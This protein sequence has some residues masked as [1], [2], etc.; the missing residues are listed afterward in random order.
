LA[1]R[2]DLKGLITSAT[3]DPESFAQHFADAQ[4]T[5]SPII[6]VSGRTYPAEMR[7][8]PLTH[9]AMADVPDDAADDM[10]DT[11]VPV[12]AVAEAV[13][14]LGQEAPGDILIFLPGEREIRDA[15]EVLGSR[16]QRNP[17]LAHADIL[18][19]FGRLLLQDQQRVF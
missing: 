12:D 1:K 11:W 13:E 17:R 2:D 15:A 6:E 8:R 14:D 16:L 3:I 7:Y 9:A 18:P 4:G 19:L 5:P 10:D